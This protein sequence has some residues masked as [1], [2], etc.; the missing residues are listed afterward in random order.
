MAKRLKAGATA[1]D[2]TFDTPWKKGLKLSAFTKK[3]TTVL[4]FL[5]Y[6]G[7]PICQMKISELRKEIGDFDK[8]AVNLLVVLESTPENVT[9]MVSEKD[10]PFVIVCDPKEKLFSL[11][12]VKPGSFFGYVTPT[13]I[14]RAIRATILGFKHGKYEG[15][16]KQLPATFIIDKNRK[17]TYAY[18]GKNV[19]DVPKTKKLLA[20]IDRG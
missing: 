10:M 9:A 20:A 5:R 11:Y 4:M 7:C 1:P 3:G 19:A 17:V 2:F 12:D 13:T 18:Y 8:R 16:E 6:M 15:N 14:I